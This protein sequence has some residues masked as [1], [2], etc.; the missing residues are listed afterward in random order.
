MVSG[1]RDFRIRRERERTAKRLQKKFSLTE[2][3]EQLETAVQN[4]V[5][6]KSRN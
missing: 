4:E 2:L 5:F 3:H 6:M 1:T